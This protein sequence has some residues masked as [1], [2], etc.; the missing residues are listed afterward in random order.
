MVAMKKQVHYETFDGKVFPDRAQAA[1]HEVAV[2]RVKRITDFFTTHFAVSA[3]DKVS[4]EDIAAK[5]GENSIEFADLV[6]TRATRRY[7]DKAGPSAAATAVV[8]RRPRGG[9]AAKTSAAA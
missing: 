2:M 5:I 1:A 6:S 7:L 8:G 4:V 9:N 3:R